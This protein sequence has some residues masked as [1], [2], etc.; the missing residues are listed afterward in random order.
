M[1]IIYIFSL[2]VSVLSLC[3]CMNTYFKIKAANEKL[4]AQIL[5]WENKWVN[6]GIYEKK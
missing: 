4:D 1:R 3:Y 2:I 5:E 6:K